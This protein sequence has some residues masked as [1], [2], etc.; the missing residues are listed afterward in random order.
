MISPAARLNLHNGADFYG[1][2]E[3]KTI[4]IQNQAGFHADGGAGAA[5]CGTPMNDSSGVAGV[6]SSGEITS[7]DTFDQWFQDVLGVNLSKPHPITLTNDG[8]GVYEY[9][10]DTFHPID[11]ALLGNDGDSHNYNFTYA[12]AAEFTYEE[13]AGQFVEFRG[14]DDAWLFIDGRL[15]LD[16]GGVGGIMDEQYIELD[17]LGL[18]DGQSYQFQFF[19]SQRQQLYSMFRLRTNLLMESMLP[20][21][22]APFD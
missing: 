8:A 4:H 21:I 15:A 13:C 6:A 12:I 14:A 5:V 19:Y 9:L 3:G 11:G 10:E 17:R 1:N 18:I 16:V 2:F 22:S 20:T 7:A